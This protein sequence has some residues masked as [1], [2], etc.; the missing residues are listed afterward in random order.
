MFTGIIEEIGKINSITRSGNTLK[1]N[2]SANK[3]LSDI[4]LGDSIAVNGVCLTVTSFNTNGFT[5]DVMP[6]TFNL[7]NLHQLKAN[8]T[9]NLERAMSANGRFGGH[10]VSGHIDCTGKIT[11]K[12][13]LENAILIDVQVPTQFMLY[14]IE[15]GSIALDG[16]SLT[17]AKCYKDSIQVSLIPHTQDESI[18]SKKSLGESINVEFDT[19]AK[20]SLQATHKSN[21]SKLDINFLQDNGFI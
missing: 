21:N 10:I 15:K 19:L 4:K 16:T 17:I 13:K 18:I 3:I 11:A 2:I 5:A 7:T 14:C 9:V 8:S 1:L 12:N 6:V 20:L